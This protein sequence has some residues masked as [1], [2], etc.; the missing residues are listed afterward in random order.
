MS[1]PKITLNKSPAAISDATTVKE[2]PSTDEQ[3]NLKS[4]RQS[5]VV[6]NKKRSMAD[7]ESNPETAAAKQEGNL[8]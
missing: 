6:L 7:V 4:Q 8:S 3:A 2:H 5:A 1:E